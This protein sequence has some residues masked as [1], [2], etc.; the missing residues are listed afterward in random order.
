MAGRFGI[1]ADRAVNYECDSV[2]TAVNY[3]ALSKAVSYVRG[4]SGC[5]SA[6]LKA[7]WK[8]EIERDYKRRHR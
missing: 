3:H 2:G 8:A 6:G 5:A 1:D 4:A 7:D